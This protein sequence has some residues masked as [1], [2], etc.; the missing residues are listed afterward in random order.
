VAE[1]QVR[2]TE[3]AANALGLKLSVIN[4]IT[5]A[6][7]DDVAVGHQTT[8]LR[9][10]KVCADRRQPMAVCQILEQQVVDHWATFH[11]FRA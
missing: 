8:G 6:E 5:E 3:T 10:F 2:D 1:P 7:F 9:K 11:P 4:A